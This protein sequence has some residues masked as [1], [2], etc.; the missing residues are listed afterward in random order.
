M[1]CPETTAGHAAPGSSGRLML[2]GSLFV[3]MCGSGPALASCDEDF[4]CIRSEKLADDRLQLV[5]ENLSE[6]PLTYTIRVRTEKLDAHGPRLVT[7]T[8]GPEE[9]QVVL[10][11]SRSDPEQA[12]R[13]R[14]NYDWTVGKIDAVHDDDVLYHL[15]YAQQKSYHVIQGYGSRFSHTG[16]EEFAVDFYMQ[17][18]TPVHAARDGVIARLEESH[19]I[20]CWEDGCGKYANFVVVLHDDGTTGEYYHLLKDGALV[21]VGQRVYAGEKIALS[22]NTGHTTVPHLHFAVYRAVEWGDTQSIP[23]RFQTTDGIIDHPRRGARYMA[24]PVI[25]TAGSRGRD[26]DREPAASAN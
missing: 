5:A 22:G 1:S 10:A 12:G 18:G 14:Y 25:R 4:I 19:S 26:P 23:V 3:L 13:Y 2:A 11:M 20:G 17:E 7:R 16:L 15:P 9:T 8:L 6:F 24:A 21:E